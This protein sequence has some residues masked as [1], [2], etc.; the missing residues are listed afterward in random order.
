MVSIDQRFDF[1]SA[2]A[3]NMCPHSGQRHYPG[4]AAKARRGFA[5]P[6]NGE[7]M[8]EFRTVSAA[9]KRQA[10]RMEQGL[11]IDAAGFLDGLGPPAPCRRP[12]GLRRQHLESRGEDILGPDL[13]RDLSVHDGPPAF[14]VAEDVRIAAYGVPK[15]SPPPIEAAPRRLTTSL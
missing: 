3:R 12:P 15:A 4:F 7:E 11:A 6:D 8:L 14:R 5:S 1:L 2:N 9:R 10:R 13:G